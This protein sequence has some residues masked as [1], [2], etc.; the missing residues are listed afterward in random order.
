MSRLVISRRHGERTR[1]KV[2]DVVIWLTVDTQRQGEK[3]QVK[4][5]FDAPPEVQIT[6][7]ELMP[8]LQR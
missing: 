2:G 1:I 8:W 7:E 4:L 3:P 6:R 5:V